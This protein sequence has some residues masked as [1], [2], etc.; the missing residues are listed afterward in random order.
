MKPADLQKLKG[1][2]LLGASPNTPDRFGKDSAAPLDRR[3]QRERDRELG[4]V[5]FAVKLHGDLIREI[6]AAAQAKGAGLNEV[7]A[8]LLREGL[9][10]QQKKK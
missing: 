7:T 8:E 5:P 2:K 6:H 9:K 10:Q 3:E 1:K 4:L